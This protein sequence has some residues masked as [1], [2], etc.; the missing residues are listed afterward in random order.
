MTK[1]RKNPFAWV[2]FAAMLIGMNGYAAEPEQPKEDQNTDQVKLVILP[3]EEKDAAALEIGDA[4]EMKLL[5]ENVSEEDISPTIVVTSTSEENAVKIVELE[6][7]EHLKAVRKL[8]T[9]L[10]ADVTLLKVHEKLELQMNAVVPEELAGKS[11][12][13]NITAK[14]TDDA[15][16]GAANLELKVKAS[17]EEKTEV[18]E[19]PEEPEDLE[20]PEQL[21][22]SEEPKEPE[23]SEQLEEPEQP[24]VLELDV[25]V[26]ALNDISAIKRGETFKMVFTIT[27]PNKTDLMNV[28]VSAD[29]AKDEDGNETLG[30]GSMTIS[31]KLKIKDHS[32]EV[33]EIKSG[34]QVIVTYEAI[35]PKDVK[36]TNLYFIYHVSSWDF[37]NNEPFAQK[38]GLEL[39]TLA[40]DTPDTSEEDKKK[41]EELKKQE[42]ELKKQ[43][44]EAKK[45]EEEL[46]KQQEEAKKKEEELKKKEEELKKKEAEAKKKKDEDAKKKAAEEKKKAAPK[47]GDHTNISVIVLCMLLAAAVVVVSVRKRI[48]K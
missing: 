38:G 14:G 37:E 42:E 47:T 20:Q 40:E 3:D 36:E 5:L 4:F 16:Y 1:K 17:D 11:I 22:V 24:E 26:E 41:E 44:E 28:F 12:A 46:K 7:N 9:A 15:V 31:D 18:P 27:N 45:K 25:K 48:L 30:I 8:E 2:C 32:F 39:L 19:Q 29:I 6:A 35:I 34:E 13:V 43:Q 21:E 10:E 23:E 33:G